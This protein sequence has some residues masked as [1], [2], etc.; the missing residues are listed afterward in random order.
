M[1]GKAFPSRTREVLRTRET[2]PPVEACAVSVSGA[3]GRAGSVAE[4]LG[5]AAR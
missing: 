2:S 3:A 1:P 4:L 5:L